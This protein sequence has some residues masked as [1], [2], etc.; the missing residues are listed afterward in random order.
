M[1]ILDNRT[2]DRVVDA[3]S[4]ALRG[5]SELS[6]LSNEF[7]V[8]AF[9]ALRTGL[10]GVERTRLMLAPGIYATN[11]PS[12]S[13]LLGGVEERSLRNTLLA[14]ASAKAC[15]EWIEQQVQVYGTKASVAHSMYLTGGPSA[16]PRA[17]QGSSTFSASG[18]GLVPSARFE[19]NTLVEGEAE[20]GG[21]LSFFDGLWTDRRLTRDAK[22]AILTELQRIYTRRPAQTV[23]FAT[24]YALFQASLDQLDEEQIV[25]SKTG[26]RDT[27]VWR[28]LYR[29]QRD[30]VLGAIDKIEHYNGC[31]IADSVGLGKTFEALAVIKY[32]ELRNDRILVLAFSLFYQLFEY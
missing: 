18:L 20:V 11:L 26:I 32:Y 8:F 30:G 28:K 9:D 5:A 25:K 10:E 13:Q 12:A 27:L 15:A 6:I 7:S 3:L 4:A 29:F 22:V 24:L 21:L 17:I 14:P 31:I 16:S 23:Y 1:T 2:H 19:M